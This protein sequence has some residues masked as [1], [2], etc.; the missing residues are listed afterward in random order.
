MQSF[1]AG[2]TNTLKFDVQGCFNAESVKV[3]GVS[4]DALGLRL[5][6]PLPTKDGSPIFRVLL[7]PMRQFKNKIVG[8]NDMYNIQ[9]CEEQLLNAICYFEICVHE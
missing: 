6:H 3:K 7:F 1:F 8:F 4:M 5:D 2:T 9:G